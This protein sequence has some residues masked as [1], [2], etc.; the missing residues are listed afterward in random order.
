MLYKSLVVEG[1]K[2]G[3][4]EGNIHKGVCGGQRS[5]GSASIKGT[6]YVVGVKTIHPYV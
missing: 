4:S 2:D 6:G 3:W 1:F 5:F